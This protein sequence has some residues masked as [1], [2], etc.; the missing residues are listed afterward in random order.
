MHARVRAE[1]SRDAINRILTRISQRRPGVFSV[2]RESGLGTVTELPNSGPPAGG[3][4]ALQA[5]Y[6][7]LAGDRM[8]F[9]ATATAAHM[10]SKGMLALLLDNDGNVGTNFTGCCF[11]R[12][13]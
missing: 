6:A 9:H 5:G 13:M 8:H 11:R 2:E 12:E 7:D 10:G 3:G 1:K 4:R